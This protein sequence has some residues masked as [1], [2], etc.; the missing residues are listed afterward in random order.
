METP[1][2]YFP[3]D[4]CGGSVEAFC[5]TGRGSG[6]PGPR[7]QQL[8]CRHLPAGGVATELT[9][10]RELTHDSGLTEKGHPTMNRKS[11]Y[12]LF[13]RHPGQ[14]KLTSHRPHKAHLL[15]KAIGNPVVGSHLVFPEVKRQPLASSFHVRVGQFG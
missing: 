10:N 8:L 4:K 9:L 3:S 11:N 6:G 5:R 14:R 13:I 1:G 7:Q 2:I 15:A 12:F